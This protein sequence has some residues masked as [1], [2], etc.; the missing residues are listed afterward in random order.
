[1]AG[2]FDGDGNADLAVARSGDDTVYVLP[3]N[4]D[5]TFG[6][7]RAMAVGGTITALAAGDVNR[8]DTRPEILVGVTFGKS[9]QILILSGSEQAG[10]NEPVSIDVAGV[11]HEIA[12]GDVTGE[13]FADIVAATNAGVVVA[14]GL[15]SARETP[16]PIAEVVS[17]GRDIHSVAIGDFSGGARSD[18]AVLR[19]GGSIDLL[20]GPDPVERR[21]ESSDRPTILEGFATTP[22]AVERIVAANVSSRAGTDLVALD[23]A[24]TSVA[25]LEGG[26]AAKA[27]SAAP[28]AFDVIGEPVAAIPMRL[29]PDAIDDLVVVTANS[30]TPVVMTSSKLRAAFP[31]TNTNDMGAGSLRDA[32]DQAN[33]LAGADT[34]TFNIAGAGPHTIALM[35]GLPQI[36]EQVDIDGTTEPDFSTTPIVVLDG[37]A[38]GTA[39][40]ITIGSSSNVKIRGLVI[41]SF[42]GPGIQASSSS[43]SIIEGC[44][45]GTTVT[46]TVAAANSGGGVVIVSTTAATVGGTTAAARNVISGNGSQ[47]VQ[48]QNF[49]GNTLIQGNF[50]GVTATGNAPLGNALNGVEITDTISTFVGDGTA[51]ASNVIS[52]NTAGGGLS[53]G[54]YAHG[55]MSD[56]TLVA[57]N[58]IGLA[59]NGTTALG[60]GANGVLND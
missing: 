20:V 14:P 10:H 32:I 57:G 5:G 16:R 42:T 54:V 23:R 21:A 34:I 48:V 43:G 40:G 35:S 55:G 9:S 29:N 8:P 15:D 12:V 11:V 13:R 1:V 60:N 53:N 47:G 33:M 7:A 27:E 49:A 56:M 50:I 45:I 18:V 2:D 3:G 37:T 19:S 6:A 24:G 30:A 26:F 25:I 58:I 31:V 28:V 41:R 39:T 4:G 22:A 51:G 46:G 44:F 52:S 17:A 38:A 36:N 59:S